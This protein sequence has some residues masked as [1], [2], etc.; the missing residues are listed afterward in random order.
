MP[1]TASPPPST[2]PASPGPAA[3]VASP[4]ADGRFLLAMADS[5]PGSLIVLEPAELR[6]IHVNRQAQRELSIDPSVP[7]GGKACEYFDGPLPEPLNRAVK[8]ALQERRVVELEFELARDGRV[9][10]IHGRFTC[11]T[12]DDGAPQALM[13]LLRDVSTERAAQ[14]ALAE[15]QLRFQAFAS[16]VDDGVFVTDLE[17]RHFHFIS[18]RTLAIWGLDEQALGRSPHCFL[19]RVLPEDRGIYLGRVATER[20]MEPADVTF[21]IRHDSLGLRWLRSR[22][23]AQPLDGGALCVYGLI[24]DVTDERER[25]LEL[26][27]ARDVAEA[28]SQA[29]SDFLAAMSHEIRT[30]MNGILGMTELLL[31]TP[32]SDKQR[33]FAQAVYRSGESL[34]EIINDVLDFSKID[35]GQVEIAASDFPLRGLMEDTLELLAPRAQDKRLRLSL[36]ESPG[37]PTVLHGDPLRLRQVMTNLVANAIKFTEAGEVTVEMQDVTGE[38]GTGAGYGLRWIRLSVRDTGIGIAPELLPRLFDAF[39]QG[40]RGMSRRYGGMGLGLAISRQLVE[41]MGGRIEARSALGEG[42]CFEVTLPFGAPAAVT[43]DAEPPTALPAWRVLLVLPHASERIA[44]E[45]MLGAWGLQVVLASQGRQ[46]LQILRGA[47]AVAPGFDLAV[48][49]D[50]LPDL[51]PAALARAL[52]EEGI[53]PD[54]KLL[55]LTTPAGARPASGAPT[56]GFH[57]EV[58]RPLRKSVMRDALLRL[59]D[60][61]PSSAAVATL[62]HRAH[63]LVVEDNVVNQ[64]VVGQML[65]GLGCR[66]RIACNAADG[67]KALCESRF[68]LVLMDI[69]MPGMDGTAAL[70]QFRAGPTRRHHFLT[71]PH[72]PVIAVTANAL[73]GDEDRFLALGFDDYLSKPFRQNQLH[74]MLKRRLSPAAPTTGLDAGA[75][76]TPAA[77]GSTPDDP[78][79]AL[80][81]VLDAQALERLRE[82]DPTG[83]NGLVTRVLKAFEGSLQRLLQQLQDAR[84][85]GDHAALRHVAHTLKSSSASVGAIELSRLCADIE[86][87]IRQDETEDLDPLLDGMVAESGRLLAVLTPALDA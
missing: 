60:A 4:M 47:T 50:D 83:A 74:T 71:P 45:N 10:L 7:L 87:R 18:P 48:V 25:E 36:V 26:Q 69:Q 79:A 80:A 21:R 17:R 23:R 30:P 52:R 70:R 29:K 24:T 5:L 12:G 68:D 31:G 64:E 55:M 14:R 72:T 61:S 27:R 81:A 41:L 73:E 63:I 51:P 40:H 1:S 8:Q 19:E 62:G 84:R 13:L 38:A 37:I 54:L 53:G 78:K 16:A 46:A 22:T 65:R 6:V 59:G 76:P 49:A 77:P 67:L 58:A 2:P 34:L 28:A 57:G 85:Q 20:R 15:S 33:R 35:S 66:V 11:V 44:L 43:A 42:S 75:G 56:P 82:L 3:S 32:L 39:T 9:R 86:R